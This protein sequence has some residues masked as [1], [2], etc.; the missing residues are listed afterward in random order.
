MAI[1]LTAGGEFAFWDLT[2]DSN[3]ATVTDWTKATAVTTSSDLYN[4][5]GYLLEVSVVITS[6][7]VQFRLDGNGSWATLIS[8]TT[9]TTPEGGVTLEFRT[10]NPGT[11]A[12]V[13]VAAKV[14]P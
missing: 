4:A 11:A 5:T 6:G 9:I 1:S 8:G 7:T 3:Q 10:A 13:Q 2:I 12:G 14:R